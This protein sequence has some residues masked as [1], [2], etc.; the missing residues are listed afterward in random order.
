MGELDLASAPENI[1]F[2]TPEQLSIVQAMHIDRMFLMAYYG[3]GKT[4]LL[5][6][7]AEYL[8]RNPSNV[9][10]FYI[11]NERTGLVE[12]LKLRFSGKVIK[13]KT[14]FKMFESYFDFPSDG[15]SPTDHVIIDEA[16]MGNPEVFLGHLKRLQSQVSTLWVALSYIRSTF[17]ESDFRKQLKDIDFSCPTLKHCLRN[18]QKIVELAQKEKSELGL[19]CFAHQVEVKNKSKV[20]DGLLIEMPL[21]YPNPIKA[22]QEAF[23]AHQPERNFIFLEKRGLENL[24]EAIPGHEFIHCKQKAGL[25]HWLES[26]KINQHLYLHDYDGYNSDV[27]GMEFQCMIYLSPFCFKC[28]YEFKNPSIITRAKASLLI[29]RFEKQDCFCGNN[30]YPKI[31][32][33]WKSKKW[34]IEEGFTMDQLPEKS[35]QV[36]ERT[37]CHRYLSSQNFEIKQ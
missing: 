19:N 5:I 36:L 27:S 29:A 7:R 16:F 10:H 17:N 15:V 2:W 25:K 6:E 13:I 4:I 37:N 31:K 30:S 22:L 33:N 28:G 18:G 8:L 20:N 23:K 32:W 3:C 9:V 11:D 35:R 34:E 1:F 14:R 26:S 24:E 21:I 12:I